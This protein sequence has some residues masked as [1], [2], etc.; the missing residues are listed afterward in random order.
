[1]RR[2]S[3]DELS[4]PGLPGYD[5][6]GQGLDVGHERRCSFCGHSEEYTGALIGGER[7]YICE[8]CLAECND[9]LIED[10]RQ[11]Q[12]RILDS[13]PAPRWL[14]RN[15]DDYVIGQE[16][17]K[18]V[19]S[20]AVY[21]HYKRLVWAARNQD[22]E[23]GK[24]NILLIGPTGSGKSY[25]ASCL[26]R[27]VDVPFAAVDATT[28]TS[29]GYAGEDVDS[30]V[31]RLLQGCGNDPEK[32][33]R[34][35]VYIDEID[36]L[37]LRGDSNGQ[38]DISGEG[39]QHALLKLIE[40][41]PVKTELAGRQRREVLVDTR[42][43]LFICGGAFEGLHDLRLAASAN[44]GVGFTAEFDAANGLISSPGAEDLQAYG[45]VPELVGRL[46]VVE[47]LDGP[48]PETLTRILTEPRNALVR[49]YKSMLD[50]DGCE[51]VFTQEALRLIARRAWERGTGA[52]GLRSVLEEILLEPMFAV[53]AAEG[54]VERI[55]VDEQ[56]VAG[57][58][59]IYEMV[60]ERRCVV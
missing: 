24:S 59:P 42:D 40:G 34:G 43:V 41:R 30:I 56:T 44:R 23:I 48:D 15:L 54:S 55:I 60:G 36:K 27:S 6:S 29:T 52:R 22:V 45:L 49:Q 58:S 11:R 21:N 7:A 57:S 18:K 37:A 50:R 35:I 16:R 17:A 31:K 32:A 33:A 39:A 46:T 5:D 26:A 20:V 28:L 13:L 25:L 1:M 8:H 47:R 2:S 12:E 14:R 3:Y 10:H 4:I 53:P 51:L 19:L 38:P 9:L